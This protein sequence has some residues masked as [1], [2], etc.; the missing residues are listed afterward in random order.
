M[1]D[2]Q[3]LAAEWAALKA[4]EEDLRYKR[5]EVEGRITA[6]TG[7][8][9][10]GSKTHEAGRYRVT[11]KGGVNRTMD[12]AAWQQIKD[13]IPEALRPVKVVEQ[14]DDAGVRYLQLNEP[15]IYAVLAQALTAKAAKP[16]VSVKLNEEEVA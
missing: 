6:N 8:R 16:Y 15:Q 13:R 14:L 2:L 1:S 7:V 4:A 11:V 5:L 12:W 3:K 10:E 9:E